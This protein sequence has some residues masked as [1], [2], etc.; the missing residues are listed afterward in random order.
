MSAYLQRGEALDYTNS[1]NTAI[2]AGD[3]I[4]FGSH[5]GVAGCDIAK[6]ETGSMHVT[7][8]WEM[9]YADNTAAAMGTNVY[10]TGTGVSATQGDSGVACGYVAVAAAAGDTTVAVKIG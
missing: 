2:E 8:V 9:P 6:G 10:W 3:V 5:V 1:G 4:V 7:G